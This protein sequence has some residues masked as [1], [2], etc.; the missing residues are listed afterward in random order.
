M[1]RPI[2]VKFGGT[3]LARLPRVLERVRSVRDG[4]SPLVLVVSARAGVT[5]RLYAMIAAPHDRA[6]HARLLAEI[7]RLHTGLGGDDT[8]HRPRIGALVRRLEQGGAPSERLR[9]RLLSEG[10]RL[11]V[12]WLA[13]RLNRAGLPAVAVDA[14]D[15]GLVVDRGPGLPTLHLRDSTRRVRSTLLNILETGTIP[16]VTG[17]F[18]RGRSG[19]VVTLG[20]GGSDYSASGIAALLRAERLELVKGEASVRTADPREVKEAPPLSALSYE[21]AEELARLGARVLHPLTMAPARS[22]GVTIWVRSLSDPFAVTVIGAAS[23]RRHRAFTR[24][25][26]LA[27]LRVNLPEAVERSVGLARVGGALARAGV[28]VKAAFGATSTLAIF[29]PRSNG[30]AA[31]AALRG[32]VGAAVV[33]DGPCDLVTVVGNGVLSD[34]PRIPTSVLSQ[35]RGLFASRLSLS[36]VVP[37]PKG[38][39]TLRA[40]HLALLPSP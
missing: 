13:D 3:A 27:A 14:D 32:A 24:S 30:P 20:R 33:R 23:G 35:S 19:E 6:R 39:D 29:V 26:P 22:A 31:V 37:E 36:I 4:D 21:E 7:E 5:D 10:E 25:G 8:E 40:L 34:V 38:V 9:D 2:V 12:R 1:A 16:V 15:L 17:Y 18:G 28:P 11:A